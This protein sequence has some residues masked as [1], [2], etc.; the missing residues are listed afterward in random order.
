MATRE[1]NKL[2]RC[3][4]IVAAARELMQQ[5]GDVGFSMRALA[6]R[7]GVSIATPYNLF[8]SKQAILVA[9]LDTD[10]EDYQRALAAMPAH[11]VDSLF[12]AVSLMADLLEREPGFYRAVLA[13]IFRDRGGELSKLVG[14]PRYLLWKRMLGEVAGKGLLDH[15]ACSDAFA[16]TLNQLN[17]TIVQEWALG[18]IGMQEMRARLRYGM[19]LTLLGIATPK[20]RRALAAHL[21]KAR[22]ELD[23]AWRA[24]LERRLESGELDSSTR[25]MLREQ[26]KQMDLVILQEKT[27]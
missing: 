11:G 27:G 22:Q 19:A 6:E 14:G 2:A 23:T 20:S 21:D 18:L 9:V 25:E 3:A 26:L 10:L 8:G 13:E 16:V 17:S 4:D 5:S 24:T 15:H 1:E 7:A 12:D